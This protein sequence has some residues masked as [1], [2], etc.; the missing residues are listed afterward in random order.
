LSD[1]EDQEPSWPQRSKCAAKKPRKC[2]A[3]IPPIESVVKALAQGCDGDAIR[4]INVQERACAKRGFRRAFSRQRDHIRGKVDTE[5][6]VCRV[7]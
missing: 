3:A 7:S 5:D 6:T 4:E 2:G 1:V